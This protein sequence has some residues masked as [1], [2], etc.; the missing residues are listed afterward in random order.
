MNITCNPSATI[1]SGSVFLCVPDEARA[2]A[3][4]QR[5]DHVNLDTG[6]IQVKPGL[7]RTPD[8]PDGLSWAV[9]INGK[10]RSTANGMLDCKEFNN[11][12]TVECTTVI[13]GI[14]TE[15]PDAADA[16]WLDCAGKDSC[17]VMRPGSI[18]SAIKQV[19]LSRNDGRY[20][21]TFAAPGQPDTMLAMSWPYITP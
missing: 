15:I 17:V 11:G 14:V 7:V 8:G 3:Q 9:T 6:S 10:K 19:S 2:M 18:E 16:G 21:A 20:S 12:K 4:V 1:G 5:F 13:D